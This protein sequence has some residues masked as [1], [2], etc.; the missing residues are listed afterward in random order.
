MFSVLRAL[1]SPG[2]GRPDGEAD[3]WRKMF[4]RMASSVLTPLQKALLVEAKAREGLG[5]TLTALAKAISAE[6]GIPLSTLKWNLR[7]LRELGLITREDGRGR[8][9]YVLTKAGRILA[10]ALSRRPCTYHR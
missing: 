5:L 6:K 4:I 9:P 7:K 10:K 2:P 1:L 8:R 3:Y